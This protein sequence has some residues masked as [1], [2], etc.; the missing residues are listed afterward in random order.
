LRGHSTA[1][2]DLTCTPEVLGNADV[3]IVVD[4]YNQIK[5]EPASDKVIR[6]WE[7]NL[8]IA[9]A[10]VAEIR[11]S[12]QE[13]ND[14]FMA[15]IYCTTDNFIPL[16]VKAKRASDLSKLIGPNEGIRA[17]YILRKDD[18]TLLNG[19]IGFDYA[20]SVFKGQIP[21]MRLASGNYILTIEVGTELKA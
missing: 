4:P 8:N 17:Y 7:G 1:V 20:S 15:H 16:E 12:P 21:L 9:D 14:E 10:L 19:E 6:I 3:K 13:Q 18:T 11:P 2:V 5:Q